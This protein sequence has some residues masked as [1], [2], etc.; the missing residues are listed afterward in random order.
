MFVI[1]L[2]T[3][4]LPLMSFGARRLKEAHVIIS[5]VEGEETPQPGKESEETQKFC[6]RS[7]VHLKES[8]NT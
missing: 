6:L 1:E 7:P 4:S 2:A 8:I 5:C 3:S